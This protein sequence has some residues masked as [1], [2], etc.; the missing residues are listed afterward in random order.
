MTDRPV[1]A[2]FV[3]CLVDVMRPRIGFAAVRLLEEAGYAVDVPAQG[4]C[5]QPNHNGGDAEGTRALARR[6]MAT[7]LPYEY[8]VA[9]SG[10]CAATIKRHYPGLFEADSDDRRRAEELAARTHELIGFLHDVAGLREV[11]GACAGVATY[12]D[13]CSGLRELGLKGQPRALL[14]AVA[15]LELRELPDAHICCGFG[16]TFAVKYPDVSNKIVSDKTAAIAE[17]GADVLVAGDL[18]CLLNMEGKLHREGRAVRAYHTAEVL[19]GMAGD[20][21]AKP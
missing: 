16:G 12:H 15:G 21:E 18:G 19:A 3:T 8:V 13:S 9:P 11:R 17:T 1:V 20:D 10:S 6:V 2:L 14:G 4:C 7:F 5:G